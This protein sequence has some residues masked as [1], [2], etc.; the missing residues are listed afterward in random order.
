MKHSSLLIGFLL[1]HLHLHDVVAKPLALY[2]VEGSVSNASIKAQQQGKSTK[3]EKMEVHSN[4]DNVEDFSNEVY[5]D[6]RT[7]KS[8]ELYQRDE[9]RLMRER[10]DMF[11]RNLASMS[12]SMSFVVVLPSSPGG[13]DFGA[14]GSE[15][16]EDVYAMV[17]MKLLGKGSDQKFGEDVASSINL[18]NTLATQGRMNARV[19]PVDV[20]ETESDFSQSSE[21]SD[22]GYGRVRAK[23]L[24]L[25]SDEEY[26]T[27]VD[28]DIRK[29]NNLA[30]SK[31]G[32][33]ARGRPSR[34][35]RRRLN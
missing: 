17:R 25:S 1:F 11:I 24:G 4:M 27:L 33:M 26:Q 12:I 16:T 34:N 3:S 14:A 22:N 8:R 2:R 19:R 31:M 9:E 13:S 30:A 7:P 18:A 29:A 21:D 28:E 15:D 6:V 35:L 23:L 10:R 32:N 20:V 5:D